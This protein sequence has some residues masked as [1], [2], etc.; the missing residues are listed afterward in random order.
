VRANVAIYSNSE[1]RCCGFGD[2][3]PLNVAY[4]V[5]VGVGRRHVLLAGRRRD[6]VHGSHSARRL[7]P[8]QRRR[9]AHPA[10]P[11]RHEASLR[12]R[13]PLVRRRPAGQPARRV[14]A[15]LLA[16]GRPLTRKSSRIRKRSAGK[17]GGKMYAVV[18][19]VRSLWVPRAGVSELRCRGVAGVKRRGI[20]PVPFSV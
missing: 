9:A 12:R 8:A 16:R 17:V 6:Q 14:S 3:H 10:Q 19:P 7:L 4:R 5:A 1:L 20:C 11:L 13:R 15:P 18:D 2:E